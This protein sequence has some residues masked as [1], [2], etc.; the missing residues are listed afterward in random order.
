MTPQD[1]IRAFIIDNFLFG[2]TSQE[3]ADDTSLIDNNLVDST[4]VLELVFFLETT[5]DI[6]V[7]DAEVVTDNLDSIGAMTAY[8]DTKR[9]A[10]A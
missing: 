9:R 2:D 6:K 10:A 7:N 5:L 4:G 3:I 1:T 8:I